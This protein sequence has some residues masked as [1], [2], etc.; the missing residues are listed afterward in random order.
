MSSTTLFPWPRLW[1][2]AA[3]H[4]EPR[5]FSERGLMLTGDYRLMT[6]FT[7]GSIDFDYMPEDQIT[8]EERYRYEIRHTS[9]P[10]ARCCCRLGA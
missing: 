7:K 9:Q 10:S 2:Q 8:N 1:S 6:K 5:W 4:L 3:F